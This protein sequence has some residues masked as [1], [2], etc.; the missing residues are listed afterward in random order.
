MATQRIFLDENPG[1]EFSTV[2]NGTRVDFAFRYNT[3][4]ERFYFS[5]KANDE[6][7]LQGRTLTGETDVLKAF[8]AI[9]TAYG[10]LVALDIDGQ[11]RDPTLENI[12][13]GDVR[14]FLVTP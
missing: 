7:L 13:R 4:S 6:F 11:G 2:I 8:G 5:M 9:S 10:S 1:Q 3:A 12:A 14:V